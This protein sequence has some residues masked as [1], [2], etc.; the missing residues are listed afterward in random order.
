MR[1]VPGADHP[2][3]PLLRH[4]KYPL[5]YLPPTRKAAVFIP[6]TITMQWAFSSKSCGI[7]LSGVAIIS[8]NTAEASFNRFTESLS[9]A[10]SG[11]IARVAASTIRMFLKPLRSTREPI[12]KALG[13]AVLGARGAP[14]LFLVEPIHQQTAEKVRKRNS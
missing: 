5:P 3:P 1:T 8:E 4:D 2:S 13:D 10:N 14:T 11:T 7:P 12:K 9:L 6:G